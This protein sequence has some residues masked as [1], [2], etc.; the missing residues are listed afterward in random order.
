MT[1]KKKSFKMP[2]LFWIMFGILLIASVLTYIIPAGNFA[3]DA[4]ENILPD[5]FSYLN[6][7]TPIT[8]WRTLTMVYDGLVGSGFIIWIV[9]AAGAMTGMVMATGAI[10]DIINWSIYK[11]QDKNESILISVMF[12]LMVYLGGFGGSDALIAVVPIGVIFSKKLKLDPIVALGV[13]TFAT[14]IGF[15][16]GPVNTSTSQMLFEVPLYGT[17][18]TMFIIMNLF[19][20]VGLFFLLRYVKKIKK[21]P[22]KSLMYSEGWDPE[23]IDTN[24]SVED[25]IG[26]TQKTMPKKSILIFAI[27]LIQYLT[28]VL[29]P[30]IGSGKTSQFAFIVS[31]NII[32]AIT[33]G[34]IAGFSF[35]KIGNEFAKGLSAMAFVAF[36]IGLARVLSMVLIDGNIMDTIVYVLTR[37]LLQLPRAFSSIFMTGLIGLLDIVVPSSASKSAT[38]IPILKPVLE[39]LNIDANIGVH[40]FQ[41]GDAFGNFLSPALGW[42]VGSC[43]MAEVPFPKW[44]KW[45]LPIIVVFFIIAFIIIFLM[46]NFNYQ[47]F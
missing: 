1:E 13:T 40:A 16:T 8:P 37:P 28:I 7:Q 6:K 27:Y 42:L 10:D 18:F 41:Y 24:D 34:F 25:V 30:I 11:L 46:T 22:T 3:L 29:Y 20:V 47:P 9:L 19:M 5:S 43:V 45:V 36:V 17:F 32:V 12:V 4:N 33:V 26:S 21:D 39:T 14:L 35:D 44:V 2:H 15:G 23:K 31:I 38:L